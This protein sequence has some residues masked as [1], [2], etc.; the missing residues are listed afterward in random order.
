MF[1]SDPNKAASPARSRTMLSGAVSSTRGEI[2]QARS[3]RAACAI[4][5]CTRERSRISIPPN[6]ST[7][8][9]VVPSLIPLDEACW[10]KHITGRSGELASTRTMALFLI[11]GTERTT[12]LSKKSGTKMEAKDIA[13]PASDKRCTCFFAP[14][15][16]EVV[17]GPLSPSAANRRT[18]VPADRRR[19]PADSAGALTIARSRSPFEPRA[20]RKI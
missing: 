17:N 19:S 5:S 16:S 14:W 13:A 2:D 7:S 6:C 11:P 9:F 10:F 20:T 1:S 3:S 12:A 18:V 4:F 8:D 15:F